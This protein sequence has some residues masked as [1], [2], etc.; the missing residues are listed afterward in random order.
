VAPPYSARSCGTTP[1]PAL[2]GKEPRP[3]RLLN[4]V[5]LRHATKA[6]SLARCSST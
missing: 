1:N 6:Y 5:P 3:C 4:L 2:Q